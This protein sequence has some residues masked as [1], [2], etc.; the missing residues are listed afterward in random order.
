MEST[1]D[2]ASTLPLSLIN[3]G[4]HIFPVRMVPQ[5]DGKI[6]KPPQRG[7]R[8]Q[9][10]STRDAGT[11]R[12]WLARWPDTSWGVDCGKSGVVAIDLDPGA[13]ESEVRHVLGLADGTPLAGPYRTPRGGTHLIY[14]EPRDRV[15]GC[16]DARRHGIGHVDVKGI[17]GYVV[18]YGSAPAV[19]QLSGLPPALTARMTAGLREPA[20]GTP[21]EVSIE[22]GTAGQ[23]P[24]AGPAR[25]M[26]RESAQRV[27]GTALAQ[28]QS[29]L[30]G[31]RNNT[32]NEVAMTCGHFVP[33][34][35]AADVVA[36]RLEAVALAVGLRPGEAAA[37]VRSGLQAGMREP[38]SRL[39]DPGEVANP[40]GDE[41]AGAEA[42]GDAADRL[43]AE[44]LDSDGL[45][46]IGDLP[47]LVKG[48]L[49]RNTVARINGK[50]THG[51][52]FVALDIAAHVGTGKPWRDNKVHQGDVVYV[53]A[54]GAEGFRKRVRAW[55][56][57]HGVS[58]SNVRFLPRPVQTRSQEWS[59]LVEACKRIGPTLIVLDTQARITVGVNENDNTEMGMVIE[60][61]ERL[62]RETGACVLLVHH[63]GH[64]GDEGRG[65]TAVKAGI[66]S[67]LLVRRDGQHIS[68]TASK[69]KDDTDILE[70]KFSM[71]I[72]EVARDEDNLPITSC[73]L[74][75]PASPFAQ[76]IPD[77]GSL[78]DE[79]AKRNQAQLDMI[80]VF[81]SIFNEGR[82][83]TK[84]E[85]MA[86]AKAKGMTR[87]S[88]YRA[89]NA[90][91]ERGVIQQVRVTD[92]ETGSTRLTANWKVVPVDERDISVNL[93]Q[94][95][96]DPT[97][98][99]PDTPQV[100]GHTE[101]KPEVDV[102]NKGSW[103]GR[104][105]GVRP[106]SRDQLA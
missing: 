99:T 75:D 70:I 9:A 19:D 20:G 105:A 81:T 50:S 69:Q 68:V 98:E 71:Q 45:E 25:A 54:E 49:S 83:G 44:M 77:Y 15:V 85:V 3:N 76:R 100:R 42:E 33:A 17:G 1:S 102:E 28:L 34:F 67:E 14:R 4:Y 93:R 103:D 60:Q 43:I 10:E 46:T 18:A 48:W 55:E 30:P 79:T 78:L 7:V 66:H 64:A 72:T 36:E 104:I 29:A 5:A 11:V 88:S 13:D 8:W 41:A 57:W 97:S 63:L 6:D 59:V 35:W 84:P 32:L 27:V 53:I 101:D 24:F 39:P 31:T 47:Y 23:D 61:A 106:D 91:V 21:V 82:G 37:T 56:R 92:T 65:A 73:V 58:M 40:D 2:A 51:K 89:W 86:M 74:I 26:T 12:A 38:Y 90:L 87:A 95:S 80:G 16:G 62:R 94:D 96:Q 22:G 52:S